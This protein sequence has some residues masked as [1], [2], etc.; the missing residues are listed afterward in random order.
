MKYWFFKLLA[1]VFK[2]VKWFFIVVICITLLG[3]LMQYA[4]GASRFEYLNHILAADREIDKFVHYYVPTHFWGKDI[5]HFITLIAAFIGMSITSNI[6]YNYNYKA[7]VDQLAQKDKTL[8]KLGE[9]EEG[10][11]K[12]AVLDEKMQKIQMTGSRKDREVLLQEFV[13]IKKQLETMGRNLA[14][15]SVDVVDSTGMKD[16]EDPLVVANDFAEYHKFAESKLNAYGCIK[17]TWTPDG[18]MACFNTVEEA[19]KAAQAMINGLKEFNRSEKRAMKRDFVIRCGINAGYLLF[20]DTLP[21]EAISDRV[22]DIA[23]HMQKYA[24]SNTIF[25]AKNIIK[26]VQSPDKFSSASKIVDDLDV[27]E[28]QPGEGGGGNDRK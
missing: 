2:L 3:L 28:W 11:K 14:F 10:A 27:Y 25:L 8:E 20:D 18:L 4:T 23:G 12:L 19:V 13:A 9:T 6:E 1:L 21:L 24:K 22:I 5:S 26:P 16:A 15:L 17:S 7:R